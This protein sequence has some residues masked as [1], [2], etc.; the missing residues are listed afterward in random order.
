MAWALLLLTILV[1]IG[2]SFEQLQSLKPSETISPGGTI[3]LS[4][5]FSSGTISDGNYPRWV[6]Q[7]P[8]TA[9]RTLIVGTSTRLPGI[10]DRFS[11]SRSGN[12]MSLT[13]SGVLVEDE[14]HYYCAVWTGNG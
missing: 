8:G 14:A 9:P 5:R 6:Q 1:C 2:P 13:I 3:T 10:P 11:G 4:C 7:I 12:T